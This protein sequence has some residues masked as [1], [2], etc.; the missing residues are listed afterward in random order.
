MLI[1]PFAVRHSQSQRP[2]LPAF[3]ALR[4]FRQYRCVYRKR[5]RH[6]EWR[7]LTHAQRGSRSRPRETLANAPY[8]ANGAI[9]KSE[10]ERAG[11][12]WLFSRPDRLSRD[13]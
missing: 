1:P 5:L 8:A 6:P 7:V 13:L 11:L 12:E 9:A 10:E 2:T 3:R 4:S